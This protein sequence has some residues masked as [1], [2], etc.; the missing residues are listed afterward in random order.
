M[1][2]SALLGAA[3]L[4]VAAGRSKQV[5]G[6]DCLLEYLKLRGSNDEMVSDGDIVAKSGCVV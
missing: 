6:D 3:T 5:E 4:L 2:A 1:D